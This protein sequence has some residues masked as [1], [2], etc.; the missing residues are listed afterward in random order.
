MAD[1]YYLTAD[2]IA[3]QR[4]VNTR[5]MQE[6]HHTETP[7]QLAAP[8]TPAG[9]LWVPVLTPGEDKLTIDFRD[10][11]VTFRGIRSAADRKVEI[12]VAAIGTV[13]APVYLWLVFCGYNLQ[14]ELDDA[15]PIVPRLAVAWSAKSSGGRDDSPFRRIGSVYTDSAGKYRVSF[16]GISYTAGYQWPPVWTDS[17]TVFCYAV[18]S[19]VTWTADLADTVE[20]HLAVWVTRAV[21]TPP[22]GLFDS[23]QQ[24]AVGTRYK[25]W[26]LADY[27]SAEVYFLFVILRNGIP[28]L[29]PQPLSHDYPPIS[30]SENDIQILAKYGPPLSRNGYTGISPEL[31]STV[32]IVTKQLTV[33]AALDRTKIAADILNPNGTI[34]TA[35]V[36][37]T[38]QQIAALGHANT[39]VTVLVDYS[40]S[41]DSV[42]HAYIRLNGNPT[43]SETIS[44]PDT[45]FEVW[46]GTVIPYE[47]GLQVNVSPDPVLPPYYR[48]RCNYLKG[49]IDSLTTRINALES[50]DQVIYSVLDNHEHRIEALEQRN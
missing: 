18:G 19:T 1:A 27:N 15:H 26:N 49:L 17:L 35:T 23:A 30:T 9:G 13:A 16:T 34:R 20:V 11:V 21:G 33:R 5:V 24:Y 2:D 32:E 28:E 29:S 36:T 41:S 50:E 10:A 40:P 25:E 8:G 14:D 43:G 45:A 38:E 42:S 31:R 6:A 12:P 22:Y 44:H 3:Y 48:G 4:E 46:V 39:P 47:D 7:G 37:L